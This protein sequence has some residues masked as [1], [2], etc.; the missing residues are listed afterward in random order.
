MRQLIMR[1]S[2]KVPPHGSYCPLR[3]PCASSS[4]ENARGEFSWSDFVSTENASWLRL[5]MIVHDIA[6]IR[7]LLCITVCYNA[8]LC[9]TCDTLYY[10]VL[11]CAT[12]SVLLCTTV[13]YHVFPKKVMYR[14][15]PLRSTVYYC[16]DIR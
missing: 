5:G 6:R 11:L 8:L 3:P 14:C 15:V 1:P 9:T 12:G 7:A 10:C 4:S 2:Q 13:W 16:G